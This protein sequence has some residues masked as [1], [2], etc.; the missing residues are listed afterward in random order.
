MPRV[1]L[2]GDQQDNT[3]VSACRSW[4][5]NAVQSHICRHI[6]KQ[7]NNGCRSD[8]SESEQIDRSGQFD[9]DLADIVAVLVDSC[10]DCR[11]RIG[12]LTVSN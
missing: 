6:D 5:Q 11:R 7:L 2:R 1:G 3:V 10:R 8:S 9:A 4:E 12:L